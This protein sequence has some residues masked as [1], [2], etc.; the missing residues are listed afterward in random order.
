MT[1]TAKFTDACIQFEKACNL[2]RNWREN[3]FGA[4]RLTQAVHEMELAIRSVR[5]A[6][7]ADENDG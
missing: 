5:E 2:G 4:T 1:Q 6:L 3:Y 7:R